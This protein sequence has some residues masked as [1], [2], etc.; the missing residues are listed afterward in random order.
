MEYVEG[1]KVTELDPLTR[2]DIDGSALADELF[3]AYL[4]QVVIDGFFH[5][6]PHPGNVF[7]TED[8]RL[9]LLD[10]G[11]IGRIPSGLRDGLL[12]LLLAIGE[13]RGDEAADRTLE[14]GERREGFDET[15]FRRCVGE[16]VGEFSQSRLGDLQ[17]GRAVIAVARA[18]GEAG[19]R[20]P[21]E[22]S[23]LGKALWSLD[24]IG[25]TLDP[26]F[27]PTASI[28]SEAPNLLRRRMAQKFSPGHLAAALL[29]AK[30][31]A[32]EMPGR[33]NR[34]LEVLSRNEL[35]LRVDA[36]DENALISG[37]Q[38][39]ANRIAMG[40]VLAALIVGAAIVM[41]IPGR[42]RILGYPAVAMMLFAAAA[43]GGVA[44]IGSIVTTDRKERKVAR[45]DRPTR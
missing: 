23:M 13:G 12:R 18:A 1:Q 28:R 42:M 17:I 30:E 8:R 15:E 3:R 43:V 33:L 36:I 7:L 2:I 4:H 37:L 31:L 45:P 21:P 20:I 39:I 40:V 9:A 35:R 34:F 26:S 6:D 22:L 5:A 24:E 11:M 44:L 38:K 29:D 16:I 10:L 25:K 19:I 14:M 41:Q 27:D 32:Q